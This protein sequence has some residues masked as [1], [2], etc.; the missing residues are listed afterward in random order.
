[1]RSLGVGVLG[2][3][4]GLLAGCVVTEIAAVALMG[5]TG[6]LP[7]S[8]PLLLALGYTTPALAVVGVI[9]ALLVDRRIRKKS[10]HGSGDGT[11]A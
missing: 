4:L 2:L 6:Q 1:M 11:V 10:D 8:T 7:E 9:V 5:D 3:F